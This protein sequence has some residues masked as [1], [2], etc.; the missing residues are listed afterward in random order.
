MSE[1]ATIAQIL[2][3]AGGWG[4]A[5]VFIA[6]Y[7]YS[8]KR[9]DSDRTRLRIERDK[10]ADDYKKLTDRLFDLI[11][12]FSHLS[13]EANI[14]QKRQNDILDKLERRQ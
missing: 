9:A 10:L 2:Q 8:L 4:T 1:I 13:A 14:L 3:T 11:G 12:Q 5:A 6:M 7:F